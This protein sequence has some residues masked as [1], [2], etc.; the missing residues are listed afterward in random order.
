MRDDS[1]A[2]RDTEIG[3]IGFSEWAHFVDFAYK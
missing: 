3:E 1:G 2:G